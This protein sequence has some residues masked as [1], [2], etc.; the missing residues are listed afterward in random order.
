MT[1][2]RQRLMEEM[3][4]RNFS[5]HTQSTY[6]RQ[7]SRFA[8]YFGQP[9]DQLGPEDIRSY[10]VYLTKE[11]KLAPGSIL[12]AVPTP[13]GS[14]PHPATWRRGLSYGAPSELNSSTNLRLTT[15]EPLYAHKAGC[16]VQDGR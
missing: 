9:P 4:V 7:V 12:L 13:W 1:A 16:R 14:S 8:R 3:Q 2:L 6:V 15:L 10:Q 5:P 11:K